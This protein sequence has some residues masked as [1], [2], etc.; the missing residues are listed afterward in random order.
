MLGLDAPAMPSC[1][2]S[3]A[4]ACLH[5][6][7][8]AYSRCSSPAAGLIMM[9]SSDEEPTDVRDPVT[10]FLQD[11]RRR[12]RHRVRGMAGCRELEVAPGLPCPSITSRFPLH[13]EG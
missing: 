8:P 2:T 5:T 3:P 9:F 4:H 6:C 1:R 11:L 12:L 13:S 10:S 7:T